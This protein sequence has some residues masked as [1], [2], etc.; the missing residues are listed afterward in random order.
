[1][2]SVPKVNGDNGPENRSEGQNLSSAVRSPLGSCFM[3]AGVFLTDHS[4]LPLDIQ[5]NLFFSLQNTDRKTF[6]TPKPA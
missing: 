4:H 1:M 3:L 6:L 5:K 2:Q